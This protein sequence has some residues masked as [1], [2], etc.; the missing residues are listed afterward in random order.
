MSE[1]QTR[2]LLCYLQCAGFE[3]YAV[4]DGEERTEVT[5]TKQAINCACCVDESFVYIKD[6]KGQK[7]ARL[8]LVMGLNLGELVSDYSTFKR[9]PQSQK[10]RLEHAIS[11]W[12]Q[13]QS[14]L[15]S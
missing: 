10:E 5:S 9:A 4:H 8:F 13:M 15:C 11:S 2:S 14:E 12:S 1:S 6:L 3:P 7:I